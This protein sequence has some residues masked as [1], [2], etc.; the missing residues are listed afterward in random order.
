MKPC[1]KETTLRLWNS[2]GLRFILVGIINTLVGTSVM[3]L[4]FNLTSAGYWISSVMNYI[5]GSIVSYFLNKYFT[6]QDSSR[7]FLQIIRFVITIAVAYLAAY[8]LAKQ[9]VLWVLAGFNEQV[10]GNTAMLIGMCAFVVLNYLLQRYFVFNVTEE[11][12]N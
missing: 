7:S 1:W 9:L 10:Q 6:F 5:V 4:L 8:G 3:F 2:T 12:N 11:R